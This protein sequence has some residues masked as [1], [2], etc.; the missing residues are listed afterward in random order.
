VLGVTPSTSE[1]VDNDNAAMANPA[2]NNFPVFC[3]IVLVPF[4]FGASFELPC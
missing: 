2:L 3:F 1:A 4:S